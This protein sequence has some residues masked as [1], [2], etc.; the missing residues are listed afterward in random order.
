MKKTMKE[1]LDMINS[2]EKKN[3]VEGTFV[4]YDPMFGD[5]GV[6][7]TPDNIGGKNIRRAGFIPFYIDDDG[8]VF[9]YTMI[10]SDPAYGGTEPQLAK[11]K[12]NDGLSSKETAV[13]EAEEELGLIKSNLSY[14]NLLGVYPY[15]QGD[16]DNI[17]VYYGE[18]KNS[19]LWSEYH[20]E[21]GW[22][23]WINLTT[24]LG[25]IRSRQQPIF[26]DLL[27]KVS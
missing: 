13:K 3:I 20:Y 18:V 4:D 12:L 14:V 5:D 1:Y 27:N 23:G 6:P 17:A 21:T 25:K 19:E 15:K 16:Q 24:D 26:K 11:G 7:I 22:T 2:I 8:D 10:P 9:A